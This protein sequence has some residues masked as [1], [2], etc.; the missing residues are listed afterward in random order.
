MLRKL[1]MHRQRY[2]VSGIDK[3]VAFAGSKRECKKAIKELHEDVWLIMKYKNLTDELIY[4]YKYNSAWDEYQQMNNS[5]EG[6]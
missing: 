1:K 6:V 3:Y 2:L 5:S 4:D